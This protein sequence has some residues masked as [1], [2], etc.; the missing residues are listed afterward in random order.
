MGELINPIGSEP[1]GDFLEEHGEIIVET[2]F[3]G[4]EVEMNEEEQL[5]YAHG[6]LER[7]KGI[8]RRTDPSGAGFMYD[9]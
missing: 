9:D 8:L 3:E 4:E 7:V 6:L 2:T 5:A 1:E